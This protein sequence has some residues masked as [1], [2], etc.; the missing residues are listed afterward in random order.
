MVQIVHWVRNAD[1]RALEARQVGDK[2][3][4]ETQFTDLEGNVALS[5]QPDRETVRLVR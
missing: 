1:G 4:P 2:W 3:P 5:S